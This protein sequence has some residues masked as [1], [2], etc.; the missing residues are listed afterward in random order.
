MTW[1][2]KESRVYLQDAVTQ[3][4]NSSVIST[5]TLDIN[6]T[7]FS[8]NSVQFTCKTYFADDN[9]LKESDSRKL[10]PTFPAILSCGMRQL[11]ILIQ[12]SIL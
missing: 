5:L 12:V 6:S 9:N 7:I 8:H 1:Q 11:S 2:L 3:Y 4:G 10:L